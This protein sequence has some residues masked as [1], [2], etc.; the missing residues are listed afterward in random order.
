MIKMDMEQ[1]NEIKEKAKEKKEK[2]AKEWCEYGWKYVNSVYTVTRKA[3]NGKSYGF[4]LKSP[5]SQ[6]EIDQIIKKNKLESLPPELWYY[7]TTISREI[8]CDS[9]PCEFDGNLNYT[10]SPSD[11]P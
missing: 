9:Y 11:I 1:W 6:E 4:I 10:N 3:Q 8:F 2:W 7:L 5:Y